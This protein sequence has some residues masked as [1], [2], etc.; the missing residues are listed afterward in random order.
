MSKEQFFSLC[1]SS[2]PDYGLFVSCRIERESL[3]RAVYLSGAW[4]NG[5][6]ASKELYR[7]K[8][9]N[10]NRYQD[11]N[12]KCDDMVER[13]NKWLKEFKKEVA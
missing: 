10:L 13:M 9:Q 3:D 11:A 8:R 12:R 4:A 7:P 5:C 1:R 6:V 2:D